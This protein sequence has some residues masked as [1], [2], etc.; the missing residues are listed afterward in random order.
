MEEEETGESPGQRAERMAWLESPFT[1]NQRMQFEGA[2]AEALQM[3]ES[4]ASVSSDPLVRGAS[5]KFRLYDM[6][7][8]LMGGGD[9]KW[10]GER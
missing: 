8:K 9:L 10:G 3:L 5:E 6:C 1:R 4:C 2:R 7:V